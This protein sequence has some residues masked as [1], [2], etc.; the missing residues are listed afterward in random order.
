[1]SWAK[2]D[3]Q[4][5]DHPKIVEVGPLGMALHTAATCYCARYLTN[6]FVPKKQI[7]KLINLEGISID[8]HA[9]TNGEVTEELIRVGLFE[10]ATGG[11]KIHD[12]DKYNPPAEQIKAEREVSRQR[13]E[14]W[15]TEHRQK[16]GKLGC[17]AVTN[18]EVTT[19]PSPSPSPVPLKE[20][21]SPIG[22]IEETLGRTD[23]VKKGDAVDMLIMGSSKQN[24][25]ILEYPVDIQ[26]I[27]REFINYFPLD[28]PGKKDKS[29]YDYWCKDLLELKKC[30]GDYGLS[31][32]QEL[33]KDWITKKYSVSHPGALCNTAKS[34]VMEKHSMDKPT[35]YK[36]PVGRP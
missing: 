27:L 11:Y 17:H 7:V 4:Y 5:P 3:D 34:K 25:P 36:P 6:G 22:E 32:I 28:I 31:I 13:Q 24:D 1:M 14:K 33:H 20:I 16:D 18:G 8:G 10:V 19:A 9:V 23:A 26:G 30:C 15:R 21:H 35:Y 2:F 12:Y 29:G